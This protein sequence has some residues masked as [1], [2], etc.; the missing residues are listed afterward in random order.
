V[1]LPDIDSDEV[2]RRL[3]VDSETN[4]IP[5]VTVS[6]E[7]TPSKIEPFLAAGAR[8]Y[9]TKPLDVKQFLE[10]VDEILGKSM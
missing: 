8:A 5:V 9:L 4:A 1:H 7:A 3:Q 10:V 2:L 6:A